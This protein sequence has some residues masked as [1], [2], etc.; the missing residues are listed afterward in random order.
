MNSTNTDTAEQ[1]VIDSV[2]RAR[3]EEVRF[4]SCAAKPERERWV[5]H[6][7]LMRL[8]L[9]FF[10]RELNSEVEISPVDVTFGQ[11]V[12]RLKRF[13]TVRSA[14][15][16]KS[17]SHFSARRKRPLFGTLSAWS[18]HAIS[19]LPMFRSFFS[20]LPRRLST[21]PGSSP[22]STCSST[23]LGVTQVSTSLIVLPQTS[24]NRSVGVRSR[25]CSARSHFFL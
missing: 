5:V 4:F 6:E 8:G 19:F 10:D 24:S 17:K 18:Q 3:E 7:F 14:G 22:I 2:R 13:P 12:F 21:L 25:V 16:R 9:K 15:T 20:R 23:S 1:E 11:P